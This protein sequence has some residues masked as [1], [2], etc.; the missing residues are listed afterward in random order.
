LELYSI[1]VSVD[2]WSLP[3]MLA[4]KQ[5]IGGNPYFPRE[6]PSW[7]KEI[8]SFFKP[9]AMDSVKTCEPASNEDSGEMSMV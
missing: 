4:G 2:L 7:Q 6:T 5:V 9:T 8:T 3:V 1:F